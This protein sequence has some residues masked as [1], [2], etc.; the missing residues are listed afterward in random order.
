MV[1]VI[2]DVEPSELRITDVIREIAARHGLKVI[3]DSCESLGSE[4][5]GVKCGNGAFA[6]G[7]LRLLSQQADNHHLS[8]RPTS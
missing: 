3:E 4:Y 7:G 8:R 2:V 5:K 6:D 1:K